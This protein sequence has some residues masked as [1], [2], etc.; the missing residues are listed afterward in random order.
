V[1]QYVSSW[2]KTLC[3]PNHLPLQDKKDASRAPITAK[4][5]ADML[6][7]A[8][9]NRVIVV[10]LHAPQVSAHRPGCTGLYRAVPGC[11][12]VVLDTVRSFSPESTAPT[13]LA[14]WRRSKVSSRSRLTTCMRHR[15]YS[16]TSRRS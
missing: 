10:D 11:C 6:E 1:H 13:R 9:A 8:G 4:L 16:S 3:L 12:T 5:V 2:T 14:N 7:V 15:C